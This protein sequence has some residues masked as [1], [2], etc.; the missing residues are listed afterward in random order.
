MSAAKIAMTFVQR[1]KH[2]TFVATI[3]NHT[4]NANQQANVHGPICCLS[5]CF[6]VPFYVTFG[7]LKQGNAWNLPDRTNNGN[8]E[9]DNK[10]KVANNMTLWVLMIALAAPVFTISTHIGFIL[11]SWL[12][13]TEEASSV[14]LFYL[15]VLFYLFFMTRQCY[16]AS[17]N[18]KPK[19][20]C[21]SIC[22]PFYP[23]RQCFKYIFG[24]VYVLCCCNT[25]CVQDRMNLTCPPF[26]CCYGCCR[27]CKYVEHHD[28]PME[29][30]ILTQTEHKEHDEEFNTKAFCIV[31]SWGWVLMLPIALVFLAFSALPITTIDLFSD[32][33]N[34]F[35]ILIL[36]AS[37][38][39][40]Y[41]IVS[42]GETEVTRFLKNMRE[43]YI[44]LT[45]N[46][47]P[48]LNEKIKKRREVD[49]IE[50]AACLVGELAEV[51]VH[52]LPQNP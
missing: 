47:A 17:S 40:T 21:C 50:A 24:L 36:F 29:D 51:V 16:S 5:Q 49:D 6:Y 15:A 37:L 39:I 48:D 44:A 34:T 31:F 19:H 8:K 23:V 2:V 13:N 3:A 10:N 26:P 11:V 12:T 38:L 43:R 30:V 20:W 45:D 35:Q 41:K 18:L 28:L 33:L 27:Y 25:V 46:T 32:L 4:M 42:L 22:L 9:T 14:A 52:K 1:A 7:T